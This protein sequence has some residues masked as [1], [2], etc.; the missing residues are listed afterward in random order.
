M[1]KPRGWHNGPHLAGVLRTQ[2]LGFKSGR[3]NAVWWLKKVICVKAPGFYLRY[4]EGNVVCMPLLAC[5]KH[6]LVQSTGQG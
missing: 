2:E 6:W 4:R 1:S 3:R 5:K